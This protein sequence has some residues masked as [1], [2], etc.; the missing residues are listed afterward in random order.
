DASMRCSAQCCLTLVFVALT[1]NVEG[2]AALRRTSP[3]DF[4]IIFKDALPS[5]TASPGQPSPT[6]PSLQPSEAATA[7]LLFLDPYQ[8]GKV[9]VV[10]IHG[11]FSS[12]EDWADAIGHLR[13]APGFAERFQIWAFRYPT[14]QGFLQSAAALRT[15]LR[16]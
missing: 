14:G 2:C 7:K 9:P 6:V 10:L 4:A 11:L 1:Y 5:D 13:A 3:P 16:I 15:Q 8:P 12:P